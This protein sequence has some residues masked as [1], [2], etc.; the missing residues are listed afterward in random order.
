[1][2]RITICIVFSIVLVYAQKFEKAFELSYPKRMYALDSIIRNDLKPKITEDPASYL[3]DVVSLRETAQKNNDKKALFYSEY[4]DFFFHVSVLELAEEDIIKEFEA[5]FKKAQNLKMPHVQSNLYNDLGYYYFKRTNP[6]YILYFDNLN[7]AYELY[8]NLSFEEYPDKVY[9][10]Y[11]LAL[12]YYQFGDYTDAIRFAKQVEPIPDGDNFVDLFTY[13]LLGMAYLKLERFDSSRIYFKKTYLFAENSAKEKQLGWTGIALGN[14]GHT[15]YIQGEYE[16]AIP[17]YLEAIEVCKKAELWDNVSPFSSRLISS[18]TK[19]GQTDKAKDFIDL[20]KKS[21]LLYNDIEGYALFYNAI[22][23]YYKATGNSL[24][25]I[26][27][28][29]SAILYND[30]IQTTFDRNSK[31]QLQL[32][33]YREKIKAQEAI[34]KLAAIR[35]QTI[36]N[37]IIGFIVF[38]LIIAYMFY[39]RQKKILQSKTVLLKEIHHRVKNNLQVISSILDIQQRSSGNEQVN[40]AF[41]D[42]K[43]RINSMALVHQNLYER[44]N[45]G[46]TDAMDYFNQLF[47]II[48]A[49]YAPENVKISSNIHASGSLN[50]D[51]LIPIALIF[52][53]LLTNTYKYAFIHKPAGDIYFFLTIKDDI[54]KMEYRDNGEG[55]PADMDLL[56]SK[57]LGSLIIKKFTQQLHG[58]YTVENSRQGIKYSFQFKMAN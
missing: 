13:N 28:R 44:E 58:S 48:S 16:Q 20:A 39:S 15:W 12:S 21:T 10:L 3:Q 27:Y 14:I 52:N 7:K 18:Y 23:D 31:V 6:N 42:A 49:S 36:R 37:T 8:K 45:V 11:A 35:Q 30:S 56:K 17:C 22:A 34:Y 29:D 51:T 55:A 54:I 40:R 43:S 57:G 9:N 25:A 47:K 5:M 32:N 19:L 50:I 1:M 53:E 4:L 41:T 46:A 26:N 24:K 33:S 38:L 2:K